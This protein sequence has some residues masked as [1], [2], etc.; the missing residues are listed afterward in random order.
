[1]AAVDKQVSMG[2]VHQGSGTLT[3]R[4]AHAQ[5]TYFD[6]DLYLPLTEP[7]NAYSYTTWLIVVL[8]K[9]DAAIEI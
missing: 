8:G 2:S 1:M 5:D 3:L 6:L 4:L 7:W 9:H